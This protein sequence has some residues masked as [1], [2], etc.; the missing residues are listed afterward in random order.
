MSRQRRIC[1]DRIARDNRHRDSRHSAQIHEDEVDSAEM[2]DSACAYVHW[3][4]IETTYANVARLS[5]IFYLILIM[6]SMKNLESTSFPQ[7]Y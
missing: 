2:I 1:G 7:E 3:N 4:D 5:L 6:D